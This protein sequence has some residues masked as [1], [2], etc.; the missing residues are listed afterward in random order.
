MGGGGD[1]RD[2]DVQ[3]DTQTDMETTE[4]I[5]KQ[6]VRQ[7]GC[8]MERKGGRERES[9]REDEI[10]RDLKARETGKPSEHNELKGSNTEKNKKCQCGRIILPTKS[11]KKPS[12]M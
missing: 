10:L 8:E 6:G 1:E 5:I 12:S 3:T 11:P 2:R 9:W 7:T 4:N